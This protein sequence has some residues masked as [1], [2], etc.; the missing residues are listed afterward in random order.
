MNVPIRFTTE[1]MVTDDC[2]VD[3]RPVRKDLAPGTAMWLSGT[4]GVTSCLE[5]VC[6]CGCGVVGAITVGEGF[7]GKAWNWDGNR[8]R[9][10]LTPSILKTTPCR[11]H[12]FLT[13]GEFISC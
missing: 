4:D 8:E 10:T 3:D 9:P 2:Y 1:D 7:G 6:P 12:G 11:W 13:S 5:F